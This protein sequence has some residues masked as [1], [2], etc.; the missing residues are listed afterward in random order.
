[1]SVAHQLHLEPFVELV[2]L[3][4]D[5]VDHRL[6]DV[7]LQS[8]VLHQPT[9]HARQI[10]IVDSSNVTRPPKLRTEGKISDQKKNRFINCVHFDDL[11]TIERDMLE[12]LEDRR[13][14]RVTTAKEHCSKPTIKISGKTVDVP[15]D[16]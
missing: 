9:R 5:G 11:D 14:H 8:V 16:G 13:L 6:D 2:G 15:G 10:L 7:L 4:E 3:V 1:M 12:Q